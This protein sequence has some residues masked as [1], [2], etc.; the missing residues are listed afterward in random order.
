MGE[1]V[2]ASKCQLDG[3]AEAL[4][5][6]DGHATDGAADGDVDERVLAAV[7]GSDMVDHYDSE[8]SDGGAVEEEEGLD[9][10]VE[11]TVDCF[12]RLVWRCVEHDYDG[13]EETG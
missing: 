2:I 4:D 1:L 10:V 9:R 7:R 12:D 11:H 8:D 6:H 5:R 13:T 3:N